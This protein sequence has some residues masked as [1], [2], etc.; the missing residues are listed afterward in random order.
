MRVYNYNIEEIQE[1]IAQHGLKCTS[2]RITIYDALMVLDHPSAEQVHAHVVKIHPSISLSTVYSTLETFAE[3]DLISR[4][5]SQDGKLRYDARLEPHVHLYCK[6]SNTIKDYLDEEFLEL[7]SN[8]FEKKK[9]KGFD[10]DD[11]NIFINGNTNQL[12]TY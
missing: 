10:I 2:Q 3:K 4:V 11:I 6:S 8:Y 9:I 12:K 7:I 1:K 5:E